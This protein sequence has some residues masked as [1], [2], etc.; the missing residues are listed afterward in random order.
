MDALRRE[1]D[2]LAQEVRL[3]RG[4]MASVYKLPLVCSIQVGCCCCCISR[5]CSGGKCSSKAALLQ[6]GMP[7]M[8]FPAAHVPAPEHSR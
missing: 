3:V 6:A 1:L 2:T 7:L 5:C 4:S 8:L